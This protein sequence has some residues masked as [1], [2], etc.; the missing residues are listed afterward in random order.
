MEIEVQIDPAPQ[1]CPVTVALYRKIPSTAATTPQQAHRMWQVLSRVEQVFQTFR[2]ALSR[3]VQPGSSVLGLVRSRRLTLQWT[4]RPR[5]RSSIERDA[6]DE[7][8]ISLGFWPGDPWTG[9]DRRAVLLVHRVRAA[10]GLSGR[11][12]SPR[13]PLP[14]AT[15]EGVRAART[16]R[17][18]ARPI[19]PPPSST[20]HRARTTRARRSRAGIQAALAYP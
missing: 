15:S 10:S 9:N 6:Y 1:E 8:V 20:S 13:R 14:S 16:T 7:E 3:Q 17:S 12:D 2:V 11:P 4:A 19:R 5:A 18:V